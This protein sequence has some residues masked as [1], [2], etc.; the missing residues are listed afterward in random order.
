MVAS[1]NLS[2]SRKLY[3]KENALCWAKAWLCLHIGSHLWSPSGI[4]PLTLSALTLHANNHQFSFCFLLFVFVA[5]ESFLLRM[6]IKIGDVRIFWWWL[7]SL[8]LKPLRCIKSCGSKVHSFLWMTT[9][10]LYRLPRFI[11]S[12]TSG[13]IFELFPLRLIIE[14]LQNF[15]NIFVRIYDPISLRFL[16][17][18]C[19]EKWVCRGICKCMVNFKKTTKLFPQLLLF[20]LF[21]VCIHTSKLWGLLFPRTK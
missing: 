12:L 9:T 11:Y 8:S 2:I 15:K 20:F 21:F 19:A 13:R 4:Q 7:L 3:T 17:S 1:V 14:L 5:A 18:E 10:S 6:P 16:C